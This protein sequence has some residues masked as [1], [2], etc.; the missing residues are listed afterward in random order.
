MTQDQE[1]ELNKIFVSGEKIARNLKGFMKESSLPFLPTDRN[2]LNLPAIGKS[3]TFETVGITPTGERILK[4]DHD[5]TRKHSPIIDQMGEVYIA[6]N[7]S[8]ASYLRELEEM[9]EN[10]REYNSI[11]SYTIGETEPV[12]WLFKYP[13]KSFTITKE[14]S[15]LSI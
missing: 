1:R 9:G 11:W 8:V 10:R 5:R 3:M 13:K 12:F 15:N 7:C 2:V 14:M 4:F 6:E